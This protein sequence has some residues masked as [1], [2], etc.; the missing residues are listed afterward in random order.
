MIN[1][2]ALSS[3]VADFHCRRVGCGVWGVGGV[4]WHASCTARVFKTGWNPQKGKKTWA[5]KK[6][7]QVSPWRWEFGT[8]SAMTRV[9]RVH[10]IWLRPGLHS[11]QVDAE[12]STGFWVCVDWVE[13]HSAKIHGI[14]S[15]WSSLHTHMFIFSHISFINNHD[16][17]GIYIPTIQELHP[18]TALVCGS[19]PIFISEC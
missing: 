15:S 18:V 11:C 5:L 19:C 13:R 10:A 1:S 8:P 14:F 6:R 12:P 2:W 3:R 17:S 7:L 4:A 9:T 16:S